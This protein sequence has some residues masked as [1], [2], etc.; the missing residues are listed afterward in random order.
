MPTQA[1][2]RS[3]AWIRFAQWR[4]RARHQ[5]RQ[6]LEDA[7]PRTMGDAVA[8]LACSLFHLLWLATLAHYAR[9]L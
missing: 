9:V 4:R 3:P 6:H 5:V 7:M 2:R 8:F 1:V